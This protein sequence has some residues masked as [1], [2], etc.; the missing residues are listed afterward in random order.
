MNIGIL[1]AGRPPE[2]MSAYGRYS[3][4]F[5][6]LLQ[7]HMPAETEFTGFAALDGVFPDS[8]EDADVWLI[9]GSAFSAYEDHPWINQL[10]A[11]IQ[12]AASRNKI[13]VGICFGHQLIA[14]ALGGSV[15]KYRGGWGVGSHT[16]T[17]QSVPE[18]MP[19]ADPITFDTYASHQDQVITM[20]ETAT[21]LASSPFCENAMM[22]IGDTILTLQTHPE[23][24]TDFARD[25]YELRRERIGDDIINSAISSLSEAPLATDAERAARWI[26]AFIQHA[27]A[28]ASP[29]SAA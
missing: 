28:K 7:P 8:V 1:E 13:L 29:A 4:V 6:R 25:L 5:E 3:A 21:L 18:W 14:Q 22:A 27:A 11:F 9:T 24:T 23:M 17:L 20:P 19:E 15:Q 12:Q 2:P 10:E 26:N 16:Y